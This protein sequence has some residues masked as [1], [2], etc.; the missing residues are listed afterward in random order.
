MHRMMFNHARIR[1]ILV[2]IALRINVREWEQPPGA[3]LVTVSAQEYK[4]DNF[5]DEL[6]AFTK[7]L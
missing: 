4:T 3:S 2:R 7:A 6:A 1:H 5:I